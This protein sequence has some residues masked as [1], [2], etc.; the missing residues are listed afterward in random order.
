MYRFPKTKNQSQKLLSVM[1]LHEG[2]EWL[3]GGLIMHEIKLIKNDGDGS[4]ISEE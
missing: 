4:R 3:F 2:S 1:K